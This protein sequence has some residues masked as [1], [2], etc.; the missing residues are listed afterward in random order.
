MDSY[1]FLVYPQ[2]VFQS[3][4]TG[5]RTK[6]LVYVSWI[7]RHPVETYKRKE[8]ELIFNS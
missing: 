4:G 2:N 3:T 7:K 1:I 6:G 5:T 8:C